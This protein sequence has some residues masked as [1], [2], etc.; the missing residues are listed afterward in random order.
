MRKIVTTISKLPPSYT[1]HCEIVLNNEDDGVVVRNFIMLYIAMTCPPRAAAETILHLLYSVKLTEEIDLLVKQVLHPILLEVI[2][3]VL[4]ESS[5]TR[6]IRTWPTRNGPLKAVFSDDQWRLI[7]RCLMLPIS[8][9]TWEHKRRA[10]MNAPHRI[11]VADQRLYKFSGERRMCDVRFRETGM[12]LP[13]SSSDE[14]YKV[15]NP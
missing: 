4:D 14:V 15:P 6:L 8:G 13:F 5:P 9:N 12:L 10:V 11:D 7:A 1:G 2:N 3:E